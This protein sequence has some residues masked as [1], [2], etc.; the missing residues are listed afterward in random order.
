MQNFGV[1][2]EEFTEQGYS[3]DFLDRIIKGFDQKDVIDGS[4]EFIAFM[5]Q[6]N[7]Q[8]KEI[9]AN[10]AVESGEIDRSKMFITDKKGNAV[11]NDSAYK[12][13]NKGTFIKT[14]GQAISEE[15]KYQYDQV[16]K[17]GTFDYNHKI[18]NSFF[19]KIIDIIKEF[20]NIISSNR[21]TIEQLQDFSSYVAINVLQVSIPIGVSIALS[22]T[23]L[24]GLMAYLFLLQA[25]LCL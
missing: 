24:G 7:G 22:G 9:I 1:S 6:Y 11:I 5:M 4:G 12:S 2:L 17:E 18:K 8:E 25:H 19:Q 20:L 14:I 23:V 13:L 3:I 10:L 21:N 16:K 15:L